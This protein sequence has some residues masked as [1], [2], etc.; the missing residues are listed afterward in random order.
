MA[1]LDARIVENHWGWTIRGIWTWIRISWA[2]P[3]SVWGIQHGITS[4]RVR[5]LIKHFQGEEGIV[6]PHQD[7]HAIWRRRVKIG[8]VSFNAGMYQK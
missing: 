2:K 1:R 5:A 7:A 6:I 4:V 8:P 3:V